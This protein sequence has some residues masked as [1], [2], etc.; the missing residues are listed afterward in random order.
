MSRGLLLSC[1]LSPTERLSVVQNKPARSLFQSPTAPSSPRKKHGTYS[2]PPSHSI[3]SLHLIFSSPTA[4]W[5]TT[6]GS[7]LGLRRRR[8]LRLAVGTA[9]R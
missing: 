6:G 8:L 2:L 7:L 1:W 4:L 3:L 9:G 5:T